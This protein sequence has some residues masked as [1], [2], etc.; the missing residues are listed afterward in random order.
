[1]NNNEI[2]K[3]KMEKKEIRIGQVENGKMVDVSPNITVVM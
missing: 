3:C 2:I 1:M